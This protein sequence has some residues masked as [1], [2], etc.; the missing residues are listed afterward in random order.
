[1]PCRAAK[2]SLLV[3]ACYRCEPMDFAAI[4]HMARHGSRRYTAPSTQQLG[5]EHTTSQ[6]CCRPKPSLGKAP[7]LWRL[8]VTSVSWSPETS[9]TA[10]PEASG[11][12]MSFAVLVSGWAQTTGVHNMATTMPGMAKQ[13]QLH[14]CRAHTMSCTPLRNGNGMPWQDVHLVAQGV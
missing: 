13:R 9:E 4:A 3:G 1:M 5:T 10:V 14:A 6:C 12:F 11:S 2:H 7:L 8:Q